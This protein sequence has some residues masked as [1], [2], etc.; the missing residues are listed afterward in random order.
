MEEMK[1]LR[2]LLKHELED[3]Y[4]AEE[5]IL[6]GLPG[7]VEQAEN[8]DLKNA[9]NEHYKVTE[10]QKERL[11]QVKRLLGEEAA[12][13]DRGFFSR[14]F[15]GEQRHHCEA[16]EALIREGENLISGEMEPEVRDAA[17]IGS[18]QKIEHYEISGYGTAKA[19]ALLLGLRRV[20][21][22]LNET[23]QEEY[24]ADLLLS[25]LAIAEVNIEAAEEEGVKGLRKLPGGRAGSGGRKSSPS[26]SPG[27]SGG[28]KKAASRKTA[29]ASTSKTAGRRAPARGR[30]TGKGKGRSTRSRGR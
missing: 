18:A 6:Q 8:P 15:S 16:M 17:I 21:D 9:L 10:R 22:L 25:D 5:Q 27:R 4:S 20:A 26:S 14:L 7:M 1:N 2:D 3:L 19:Y 23:L 24:E 30:S 28:R 12:S 13:E 29:G 11:D